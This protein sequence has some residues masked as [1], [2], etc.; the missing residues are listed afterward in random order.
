M[1]ETI[2]IL[3]I[4]D[5]FK[6]PY[7]GTEGQLLKLF[8][9]LDR[10]KFSPVLVILRDSFFQSYNESPITTDVPFQADVLNI[11]GI[12]SLDSWVKLYRYFKAKKNEGFSVAHTYF[13]DATLICPSILKL[14]GFKVFVARRDMGY[15]Y[16]KM[17]LALLRIN[18]FFVDCVVANSQAVKAVTMQKEGYASNLVKVIYNG[19]QE[20]S[21]I[22]Q[23]ELVKDIA[24]D[25][26]NVVLVAN[27]RPIKRV[28]DAIKAIRL[29]SDSI[30]KIALYIIGDGDSASLLNLS[31][32]IGIAS[33]IH[34]IGPRDD[35][36][37]LLGS[38]DVGILCSESEGFSNT[39]IE[40]LQAGLP[41]VCSNVGGNPEIIE[42]G[43]NGFLYETG[44][45]QVLSHNLVKL[46]NDKC[47]R[48]NM[49]RLGKDKAE[50]NYSLINYLERHQELYENIN[51]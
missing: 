36:T 33:S 13:Y 27:I 2:K 38:F 1:S 9:G 19:Y 10:E 34:F 29:A 21:K 20:V 5:C 12:T 7:A 11:K 24:V 40:Y 50:N 8:E 47:L 32:E 26:F 18:A 42:D 17:N 51:S 45:I 30:E 25:A 28:Q 46:Q 48:V 3:Y 31:E 4:I 43:V 35:I 44:D 6:N 14:L 41:A 39:L 15:W 23:S 16:T 22:N 37:S 49:G